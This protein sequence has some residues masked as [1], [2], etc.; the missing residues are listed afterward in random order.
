M[1]TKPARSKKQ[2]PIRVLLLTTCCVLL[3]VAVA[4][5]SRYYYGHKVHAASDTLG[6]YPQ[7][8]AVS[9]WQLDKVEKSHQ[10]EGYASLTSAPPGG[11]IGFHIS[12]RAGSFTTDIYR[13]G[14]YGGAGAKGLSELTNRACRSNSIPAPSKSTGLVN[15]DWPVTFRL[16]VP[17][18]WKPG[19]YLAKLTSNDGYQNYVPFIVRS[20]KVRSKYL[21]VHSINTDNAYNQW[22]GNSLY[23]GS[24]P[25]LNITRAVEASLNRPFSMPGGNNDGSG[26]FLIWEYPMVRFLEKNGYNVDY[27]T[28]IDIQEHPDLLLK[29]KAVIITGH[30]EYWSKQMRDGYDAALAHGVNLAVF[31][32]NTAYRPVRFDPDPLTGQP[33]RIM[34]NYKSSLLDPL[35]KIKPELSTPSNWRI[36]PLYKPESELLGIAYSNETGHNGTDSDDLVVNDD[37]SWI[38]KGT[39]L[40]KGDKIPG[41]VGYEYEKL[42]DNLPHPSNV[43]IIFHS[44]LININGAQDFSDA[45]YYQSS[46]GGQVFDSGTMEWSW[47]LDPSSADYSPP[48]VQATKNILNRFGET[49]LSI[50]QF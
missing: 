49:S 8:L 38:F 17:L 11:T 42:V 18:T 37:S 45:G 15:L 33:D 19:V 28:D 26:D 44:P 5:S 4:I 35:T 7:A 24:T 2:R 13:M 34:V 21:F 40:K 16:H 43:D 3:A 9:S 50:R 39:H 12:C 20:A 46:S 23:T 41:L 48:I 29:Y 27:A 25:D 36:G 47:G 32:A 14:W 1:P 22:G 30:D 31:A 6:V 10:I